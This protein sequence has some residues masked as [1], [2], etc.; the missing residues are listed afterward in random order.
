MNTLIARTLA[1][2]LMLAAPA[3]AQVTGLGV[4]GDSLSDEYAEETYGSYAQNWPTF[5]SG[6]P[7]GVSLGPTAAAA[8]QSGGT[9]GEPR[10]SG[11]QF[12]WARSGASSATLISQGQHTGL[13]AMIGPQNI[14]HTVLFIGANDFNPANSPYINI[15]LGLWSATT[16]SN[17]VAGVVANIQTAINAIKPT[18][19]RIILVNVVDPGL[20]PVTRSTWSSAAG[21]DRVNATIADLNARLKVLAYQQGLVLIDV[22]R[23]TKVIFGSNAAPSPTFTVGGVVIQLLQG[24]TTAGGNPTAGFVDDRFH[25]N[26]TIQGVMAN[27]M[28]TALNIAN[29]LPIPMFSE[30]QILAARG[31]AAAGPDSV[32]QQIGGYASYIYNGRCPADVDGNGAVGASDLSLLLASYGTAAGQPGFI[33]DADV[34]GSGSVGANDLSIVLAAYGQTC[35]N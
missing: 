30:G 19:A 24:D 9:W 20:A 12:N 3:A 32:P 14:S 16:R 10:R 8:G 18:G 22:Y 7:A 4:M 35:P 5:L 2:L 29:P 23:L 34:D 21:R 31:L 1:M 15:Y 26:T 13:A 11:Y 17:Y 25:P 33:P 6:L 27:L 28:I